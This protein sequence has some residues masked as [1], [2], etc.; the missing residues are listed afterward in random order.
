MQEVVHQE[1][2]ARDHWWFRARR[3]IFDRV[4][5]E[6]I[7]LPE[8]ARILDLGPGSGVNMPVLG[9]RGR[10]TVVDVSPFSLAE[11]REQG[12][13]SVVLA[14]A[15]RPPFGDAS[16]DLVTALD[17]FEHIE[18]DQSAMAAARRALKPGG[19]LLASV[20]ALD[21]LWGRQDVLSH[22]VRRYS[23]G[24]FRA[25]LEGA[26]FVLERLTYFN[27]VLFPPILATRLAMR[28]FLRWTRRGG[29]DLNVRLPLGLDSVLYGLFAMEA[30]WLA[31]RDLPLGVSLLAV[32]R[33]R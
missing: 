8:G 25:R 29:S 26:G 31:R 33:P 9:P 22:H 19:R 14:D 13:R 12:A 16:F 32:A 1:H 11:C 24:Q 2:L 18:D 23:R 10:V 21:L 3:R 7:D 5:D 27:S 20:P 4:L 15:T 17:V 30:G 6:G 28:P